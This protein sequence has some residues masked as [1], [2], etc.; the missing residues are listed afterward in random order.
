[1]VN[2]LIF[3]FVVA[4]HWIFLVL[5]GVS[6]PLLLICEPFYISIP[7]SAWIMHLGWSRVLECPWTRV[8]NYY[9][10]KLGMR[11]IKT[12]IGYYIKGKR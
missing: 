4:T 9:R 7:M 5:C 6:V 2:R 3:Y 8:E 10:R 1:M 11:E 12:F